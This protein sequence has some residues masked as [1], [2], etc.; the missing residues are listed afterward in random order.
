M[1]KLYRG[2]P[3]IVALMADSDYR[4]LLDRAREEL[5]EELTEEARWDPPQVETQLEGSTTIITNYRE[6]LDRLNRESDHLFPYLLRELGTAGDADGDRAILQGNRRPRDIQEKLDAY[7]DKYVICSECRR[8]DTH[9]E[10]VERTQVLRCDACGAHSPLQAKKTTQ[11]TEDKGV[12]EGDRVKVQIVDTGRK[13]DGVAKRGDFTI[14]VTGAQEGE[15]VTA[16][17]EKISGNIAFAHV[18]ERH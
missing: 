5:P 4:A 2:G 12:G 14:F 17:I 8:P 6:I 3:S 16:E 10:K 7:V 18:V 1:R 9:L 15:E 13:G 11:R